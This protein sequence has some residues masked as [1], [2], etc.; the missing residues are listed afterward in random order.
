MSESSFSS[1]FVLE[2]PADM[3]LYSDLQRIHTSTSGFNEIWELRRLG[4]LHVL[5]TLHPQYAG[6]PLYEKL[7]QKEF[8][9]AY[10]LEHIHICRTLGW[11]KHDSLGNCILMEYI[12]GSTLS[13]FMESGQL[14]LSLAYK[15]IDEL[16]DALQYIHSKQVIHRDLKPANILITHNGYNVKLIDFGLSDRD[17]YHTLKIPAGTRHYIAP[18]QLQ[19]GISPDARAD[20]YSLGVI[21]AEMGARLNNSRLNK[22]ARKCMRI[23]RDTRYATTAEVK[24]ALHVRSYRSY[25]Q[26]AAIIALM[27]VGTSYFYLRSDARQPVPGSAI[28]A[29]VYNNSVTSSSYRQTF[30]LGRAQLSQPASS[31]RTHEQWSAD[32]LRWLQACKQALDKEFPLPAQRQQLAYKQ[33]LE[34]LHQSVA[35]EVTALRQKRN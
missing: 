10:K 2:I 31:T 17:D 9:I 13:N 28:S 26:V 12:D 19:E 16:C 1:G 25:Y 27:V 22:V 29:S 30:L 8:D 33:Q 3:E 6:N 18:E 24:T 20:I 21:I 35:Q 34:E 23:N 7:L 11:E 5:K 15:I 32:S 4:K 14:T